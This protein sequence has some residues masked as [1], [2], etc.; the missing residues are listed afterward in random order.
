MANIHLLRIPK[1]E[2]ERE[3]QN[4]NDNMKRHEWK[5]T[6]LGERYKFID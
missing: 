4:D 1:E 3:A 5:F 2:V 6:Q